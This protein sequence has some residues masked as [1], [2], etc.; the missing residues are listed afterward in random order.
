MFV[1]LLEM[2]KIIILRHFLEQM[3]IIKISLET[4]NL[5]LLLG[6]K[7]E[8]LIY[9]VPGVMSATWNA[10]IYNIGIPQEDMDGTTNL[11]F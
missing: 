4:V 1:V 7:K 2:K 9:I 3:S 11:F 10:K 6:K 8:N 5:T